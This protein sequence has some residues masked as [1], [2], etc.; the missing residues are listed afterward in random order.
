ML[1]GRGLKDTIEPISIREYFYKEGKRKSKT[2]WNCPYYSKW[3]HM[4]K[5][6]Y[7]LKFLAK[8]PSYHD[9]EVCEEWLLFSVFRVWCI[10]YETANGV[11]VSDY[12]L[13]K[14]ILQNSKI[15][16]P[17][18]CIFVKNKINSFIIEKVK[19]KGLPTGV[20]YNKQRGKFSVYCRNPFSGKTENLG[21]ASSPEEGHVTWKGRKLE[22]VV[23]FYKNGE[24]CDEVYKAL[25][26]RYT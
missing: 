7:C 6:C 5:R 13:D 24:V 9:C 12:Q 4:L 14:D 16:S 20:S 15:Y 11:S 8:Y 17:E 2:I 25:R 10:A 1:Y 3:S 26:E 23:Q 18:S 19:D 22:H 21:Y